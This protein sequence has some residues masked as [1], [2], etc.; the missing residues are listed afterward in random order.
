M[1]ENYIF[2]I[3]QRLKSID[4]KIDKILKIIETDNNKEKEI[5]DRPTKI[6]EDEKCIWYDNLGW[7]S[8]KTGL[9]K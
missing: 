6:I 2:G 8:T 3:I 1:P 9:K 7:I 4:N 5:T